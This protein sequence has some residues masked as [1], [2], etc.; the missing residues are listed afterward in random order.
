MLTV[1]QCIPA[2]DHGHVDSRGE[3]ALP[4]FS[5]VHYLVYEVHYTGQ[6]V[7]ENMENHLGFHPG[8]SQK[9][10]HKSSFLENAILDI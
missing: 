4:M 9:S 7:L 3:H 6:T 5:A 2:F 10:M 8:P 1:K